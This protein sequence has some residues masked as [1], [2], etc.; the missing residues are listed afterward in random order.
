MAQRFMGY[1]ASII[2]CTS[3]IVSCTMLP[4]RESGTPE[5]R[6]FTLLQI[7]DVYKIEGLQKGEIGGLARVRTLRRKLEDEGRPVLMLL[8]GDFLY[9]SVMSK[10]LH[11]QP[12]VK[13]LNLMD[14]DPNAF[15]EHLVVTF[16]NHEFDNPDGGILLGRIA[17]SDFDWVSSNVR[18]LTTPEA[19]SESF[20][21]RL[22]NIHDVITRDL[23]GIR[24][25]IF[26]VTLDSRSRDYIRYTYAPE[27]RR[28]AVQAALTQMRNEGAQ[29][30]IALTHQDLAEDEHMV[31]N[32]PEIDLVIGGHEHF[33]IQRRIGHTWITK[34]D[35]DAQSTLVYDIRVSGKG[36][37]E[38]VP[39]LVKL[40]GHIAKDTLVE[41]EV[42]HYLNELREVIKGQTRRDPMQEIGRTRYLLEGIEPVVRGR[43]TALGDFLADV[44]RERLKTDI[45]FV[46]GG[47]IRIN[48]N[49]PPGPVTVYDL[50]GI[51]Y[52]ENT[53]AACEITGAQLLDILRNSVSK[54]H[55]GN[56]RFLQVS[57]LRF[58]Y[59]VAGTTDKPSYRIEADDV[60]IQPR[61]TE[62]YVSLDIQRKYTAGMTDFIWQ[63]GFRDGYELFSRG[64]NGS[65][66]PQL[67]LSTPMDF[68]KAVEEAIAALPDRT[69]T[70]QVEERI[71]PVKK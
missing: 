65:S 15:D 35:S 44:I 60:Q 66:P 38:A 47:S 70:T 41:H 45:A 34:A 32:F 17:Q 36:E 12:M 6:R 63:N 2:L 56:G 58:R 20:N 19:E 46:N 27:E 4:H 29:F 21:R 40:D 37:I 11:A 26:S 68:R 33:Y 8:A 10:Y 51:F 39:R 31:E 16:G 7:N 48:D 23:G 71:T 42:A 69:I 13:I 14:G 1:L 64:K 22:K 50:E 5:E 30:I 61:G 59:H 28:A 3:L 53:L 67:P 57:G 62:G 54:V 24:V 18:Y 43:E 55:L 9:P 52:F 49:I 25:G